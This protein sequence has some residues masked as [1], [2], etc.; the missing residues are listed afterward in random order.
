MRY[1]IVV[2]FFINFWMCIF[3]VYPFDVGIIYTVSEK[4]SRTLSI[5]T[6]RRDINFNN[7]WYEYFWHNWPSNDHSI[8]YLTQCLF[9]HYLGK[10]NQRN[11]YVKTCPQHYWLLLEEELTDFNN[12]WCKHLWHYLPLNGHSSSHL[13]KCLFLHYVGK[14]KQVK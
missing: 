14:P 10:Q 13:T 8:F 11:R 12:F 2:M 7:F 3:F 4:T 6:W 5:V 9:L 1:F